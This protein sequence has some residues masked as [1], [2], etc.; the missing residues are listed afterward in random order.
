MNFKTAIPRIILGTIF[1]VS[2]LNGFFNFLP[3]QGFS[4]GGAAFVASLQEAG[5]LW[6]FI[7]LTEVVAGTLLLFN[8]AGQLGVLLLAP[9]CAGI[10][11]FH[12]FL[13][14][15]GAGLGWAVIALE[16]ILIYFWRDN[17]KKIFDDPDESLVS[18]SSKKE[19]GSKTR[20]GEKNGEYS[21][22]N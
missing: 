15:Q 6:S 10:F 1:L 18:A 13:S 2:G 22:S 7:K 16:A 8:V 20:E 4:E 9:I 14:P 3:M 19:E 12:T 17:F 5:F 11:F 21:Y